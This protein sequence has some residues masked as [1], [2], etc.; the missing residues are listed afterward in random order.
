MYSTSNNASPFSSLSSSWTAI[1]VPPPGKK[2]TVE[3][4]T[5]VDLTE[6][7]QITPFTAP[8]SSEKARLSLSETGTYSVQMDR[9]YGSA[10]ATFAYDESPASAQSESPRREV[11]HLEI[12]KMRQDQT[13]YVLNDD[14]METQELRPDIKK[15]LLNIQN[16]AVD[17][18][19]EHYKPLF[20]RTSPEAVQGKPSLFG[21][22]SLFK[23]CW[24]WDMSSRREVHIHNP[25]SD[26]Q[27]AKQQDIILRTA[28]FVIGGLIAFGVSHFLGNELNRY[29]QASE[30]QKQVTNLHNILAPT[31]LNNLKTD[32]IQIQHTAEQFFSKIKEQ[33]RRNLLIQGAGL[34]FAASAIGTAVLAPELMGIAA[35]YGIVVGSAWLINRS[36]SRNHAQAISSRFSELGARLAPSR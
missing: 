28:L 26:R 21:K 2:P 9:L 24:F 20:E 5:L 16:A 18:F 6:D 13:V 23:N 17:L 29:L 12:P 1:P 33:A 34:T 36:Y 14:Q 19:T 4:S 35:I 15:T 7:V 11:K 25:E 32:L 8:Y 30:G 3:P 31:R 27:R 22:I 10:P